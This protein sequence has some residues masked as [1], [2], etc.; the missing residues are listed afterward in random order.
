MRIN[1]SI[2]SNGQ[3]LGAVLRGHYAY[4]G[5]PRNYRALQFFYDEVTRLWFKRLRRRGQRRR[6]SWEKMR[7]CI[8]PRYLPPP[9]IVHPWPSERF[10]VRGLVSPT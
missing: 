9:R 1:M 4:F 8:K 5:V 10:D 2:N 6:L 3:W 7:T